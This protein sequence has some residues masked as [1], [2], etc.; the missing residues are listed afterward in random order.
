MYLK[1]T[2]LDSELIYDGNFM[3]IH[4][5]IVELPNKNISKRLYIKHSGAACILAITNDHQLILVKQWRYATGQAL[6][7]I[8]A[9]KLNL[10]E[11]PKICALRELAEETPYSA[12]DAEKL[13]EFYTAPGFC[14]ELMHL[15]MAI[16]VEK[17]S[18]LMPDNDEFV[19]TILLNKEEVHFALKKG[20]I[21]DAK[22]LIAIQ[23]WLA[24]D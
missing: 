2:Q 5:D 14:N 19:E 8:P 3:S 7:E 4:Q 1:E 15:Y 23:F 6:L 24:N 17:N 18:K 12:Q 13:M 16:N 10:N 20:E 22:T 9:G 21:Q 11:D